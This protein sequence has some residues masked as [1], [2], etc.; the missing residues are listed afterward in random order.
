MANW[1]SWTRRWAVSEEALD[2]VFDPFSLP[3]AQHRAGL[4]GFLVLLGSMARRGLAPLPGWSAAADG[5]I[6]V[7]L[8]R[9]SLQN[10]LDD[11]YDGTWE[12]RRSHGKP[13]GKKIRNVREIETTDATGKRSRTYSYEAVTPK[14]AF[15][16]GMPPVW[17]KLWRESIWATL[18]GI[19]MTRTPYE[20]RAARQHARQVG[21][22]WKDLSKAGERRPGGRFHTVDLAGSLFVGA[23]AAN[24]E[25]VPFRSR[26]DEAFL[27]HFWPVVMG[28]YVPETIDRDGR[29]Q[30][31]G[32][33]LAVPDVSDPLDFAAEFPSTLAQLGH[34]L[35]GYRPREAVISVPQEG[36]LEYLVHLAHFA[37][38]KAQQTEISYSVTGVEVYQIERRGNNIHVLAA[39]RVEAA[40]DLLDQYETI[41][42]RYH[43][44]LFRRQIVLNLLRGEAWYRTFDR[45]LAVHDHTRFVGGLAHRFS[46]DCRRRFETEHDQGRSA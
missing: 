46:G 2:L 32:H 20:E 14:A 7:A 1:A 39:E 26:A 29:T 35:A 18:R 16:K 38:A 24:A 17:L 28:V 13:Q 6:R 43:D 9:R 30:F 5:T 34:E 31:V 45:V 44:P 25:R 22:I 23:Q 36:A 40:P 3:T 11:L 4:A 37:R 8:T 41:R 19:P 42:H 15:L 27:L 10:V 12:E 33:V 21:S